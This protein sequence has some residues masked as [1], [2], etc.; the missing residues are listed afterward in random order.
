MII[1]ARPKRE[2]PEDG[3][4]SRRWWS[5]ADL[6]YLDEHYPKGTP[7]R[8]IARNL[9]RTRETVLSKASRRGLKRPERKGIGV[10]TKPPKGRWKK[11]GE[12]IDERAIFAGPVEWA[13]GSEEWRAVADARSELGLP[14]RHRD[15]GRTE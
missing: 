4:L 15:D 2:T 10:V 14:R 3:R 9:R 13:V 12:L 8:V 7:V 1:D 6:A 5:A 11:P